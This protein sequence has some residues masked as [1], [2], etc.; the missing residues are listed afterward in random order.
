MKSFSK[1]LSLISCLLSPSII[2][3]F[4]LDLRDFVNNYFS[5][6][7]KI[8]VP[9]LVG[10]AFL[11]FFWGLAKFILKTDN[12]TEVAKGK[13]FMIWGAFALFILTSFWGIMQFLSNQ[14]DFGPIKHQSPLLPTSNSSVN[15][16]YDGF[17]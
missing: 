6:T 1:I 10:I 5:T 8:I 9:I 16:N 15:I 12:T 4:P 11:V 3:A 17:N 7:F 2:F 14:F 13:Q